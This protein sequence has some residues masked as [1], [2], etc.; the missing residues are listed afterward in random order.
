[1]RVLGLDPGMSLGYAFG[2]PSDKPYCGVLKLPGFTDDARAASFGGAY[3]AVQSMVR[4]HRIEGVVLEAPLMEIWRKNKRGINTP[5][6][7]HGVRMHHM[8]SGALQAAVINSGAKLLGMPTPNEW[9]KRVLGNAFPKDPKNAA[10]AYCKLVLKL[11][12]EE[13]D[14]AEAACLWA[15]GC[16]QAKLL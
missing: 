10:I 15:Y 7:S 13:H 8:L 1:M 2:A 14:A 3:A 9:R 11:T 16:G 12:V 6:S 5:S 4:A